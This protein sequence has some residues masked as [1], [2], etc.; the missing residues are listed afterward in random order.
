MR[1][2]T[3]AEM[4]A[5]GYD[6]LEILRSREVLGLVELAAVPSSPMLA[7]GVLEVRGKMIPLMDLRVNLD[8]SRSDAADPATA[9]IVRI[10]QREVGLMLGPACEA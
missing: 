2:R 7:K 5:R 10:G 4:L 3:P 6:L 8:A 9:L 1:R